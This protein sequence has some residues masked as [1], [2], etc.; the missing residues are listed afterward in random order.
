MLSTDDNFDFWYPTAVGA[1]TLAV[2]C[3]CAGTCTGLVPTFTFLDRQNNAISHASSPL[4]CSTG[5]TLT[6]YRTITVSD[7]DRILAG[8]EGFRLTVINTPAN[9]ASRVTVCVTY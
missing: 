8:G 2:G 7:V 3:H 6:T 9:Q 1:T 4:V 5:A